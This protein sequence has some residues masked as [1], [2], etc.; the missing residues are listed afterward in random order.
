MATWRTKSPHILP[1]YACQQ[2]DVC[3]AVALIHQLLA[4]KIR[5]DEHLSIQELINMLLR[6]YR[7]YEGSI[8]GSY[9]AKY[10]LTKRGTVLDSVC[11]LTYALDRPGQQTPEITEIARVTIRVPWTESYPTLTGKGGIY[12]PT[13]DEIATANLLGYGHFLLVLSPVTIDGVQCWECQDSFGSCWG[14]NGGCVYIRRKLD[15]VQSLFIWR[16]DFL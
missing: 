11:P 9:F 14:K 1:P 10:Y 2:C 13:A 12:Q 6:R 7:E 3:W 15:L 4:G 16:F 5:L 8:H